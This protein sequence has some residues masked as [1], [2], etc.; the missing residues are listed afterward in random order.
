MMNFP[1]DVLQRHLCH[2]GRPGRFTSGHRVPCHGGGPNAATLVRRQMLHLRRPRGSG[3]RWEN[4]MG[5]VGEMMGTYWGE[6]MEHNVSPG[7]IGGVPFKCQIVTIGG[8][9]P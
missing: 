3:K 4:P 9:P 5:N 6:H 2:P 1:I 7:L 8:L